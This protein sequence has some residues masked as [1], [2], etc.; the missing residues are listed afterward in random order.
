MYEDYAKLIIHSLFDKLMS[1]YRKNDTLAYIKAEYSSI[2]P[3]L[4]S[5]FSERLKKY[6]DI[7]SRPLVYLNTVLY[8]LDNET[9]YILAVIDYISSMTD[10]YAK[11]L[12]DE[13]TSF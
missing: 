3:E 9:D 12:F 13:M 10:M 6:S 5:S 2:Y 8:N 11:K 4:A 1:F 7:P